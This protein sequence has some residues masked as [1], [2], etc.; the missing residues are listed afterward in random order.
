MVVLPLVEG[1]QATEEIMSDHGMRSS[2]SQDV[3]D[4]CSAAMQMYRVAVVAGADASG[5]ADGGG[6]KK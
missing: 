4:K 2:T 6:E 3:L 5:G 1:G